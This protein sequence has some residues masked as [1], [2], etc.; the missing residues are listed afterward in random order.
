MNRSS[1]SSV[2]Y[3]VLKEIFVHC[4]P[5]NPFDDRQPNTKIAPMLLCQV[6]SSWR[7]VAFASVSL[8]SH[9]YF[10]LAFSPTDSSNPD[11]L[12]F[13]I[14]KN[15]WQ[16]QF[17]LWWRKNQGILRPS[18]RIDSQFEVP[19]LEDCHLDSSEM[20][21]LFE[22]IT[23]AQYLELDSAYWRIIEARIHR[24]DRVEFPN[25]HTLFN[26]SSQFEA[27]YSV[28]SLVQ[29]HS[30]SSLRKLYIDYNAPPHDFTMPGY[31]GTLTHIFL[32]IDDLVIPFQSWFTLLRGVPELQWGYFGFSLTNI[33]SC[34][35]PTTECT[36]SR[37]STITIAIE[38]T[39]A[40]GRNFSFASIFTKFV[41]PSLHTLS[42]YCDCFSWYGHQAI[43][44]LY[45]ILD[46]ASAIT[47][48]A[49]G[50]N[51][52]SLDYEWTENILA[53]LTL[54]SDTN[55]IWIHANCLTNL[56]LVLQRYNIMNETDAKELLDIFVRNLFS[57]SSW[58]DL[59]DPE[60]PIQT[61]TLL[62][63]MFPLANNLDDTEFSQIFYSKLSEIAQKKA[64]NI[65][66]QI[67]SK[68][69]FQDTM[70]DIWNEWRS[71]A[72]E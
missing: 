19:H 54:A 5:K 61:I 59:D 1:I 66:F 3:D 52:L 58:L 48:L 22:Y 24:G 64:P 10:C 65:S 11:S 33:A 35:F 26:Y 4:L 67:T 9:L 50:L 30:A 27:F 36:L 20:A 42:L 68:S 23:S 29:N 51:F 43:S 37:L 55:P 21:S 8:W 39:G 13:G 7:T 38:S 70:G 56:Q 34:I 62:N 44:Q 69:V 16:F 14:L 49:L 60:C 18:L 2:P 17:L 57:N 25:L 46:S 47:T 32:S 31:W 15:H 71:R 41:L 12:N 40:V 28:Q 45:T 53:S 6:C 72:T 63:E